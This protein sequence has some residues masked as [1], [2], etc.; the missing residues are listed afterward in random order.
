MKH[1]K[2]GEVFT[3]TILAVACV[4]SFLFG[5]I[6]PVKG[7]F[8]LGGSGK[9]RTQ[10]KIVKSESKPIIVKGADGTPYIL[11]AS[12][13]ETSTMDLSEE[14]KMTLWQRLM[15]LPRL[16]VILMLLG[17]FFPPIAGI[18]GILNR[19]LWAEAKKI[20][21]GVEESLKDL[22]TTSPEAKKKVLDTL[23][24][25]YDSST[26]ALVSKIKRTL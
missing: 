5:M 25:K 20:V 11:Q 9:N 3:L 13:T 18:M 16:W 22:D 24:K 2:R 7:I 4:A 15:V 10:T 26:K 12:K 21:G 8:G 17:I 23:S 1:N 6:N 14:P 19:K